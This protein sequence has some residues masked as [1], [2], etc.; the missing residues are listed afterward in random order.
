MTEETAFQIYKDLLR[1]GLSKYTKKAFCVLPE[2]DK[3]RI[4]DIGCGSGVPTMELARLSD[5]QI[6]GLDINQSL[7]DRLAIKVEEAGLTDRVKTLKCSIFDMDFPDESFDI[8]WSE[9]SIA[10][11]GFKKGLEEWRRL[12]KPNGFLAVHDEMGNVTEKLEQVSGCGY[13]LLEYFTLGEDTWW[14]E[15]YAPLEKRINEI[16]TEHATDPEVL[17]ELD[18]DQQEIDMFKKNPGRYT[19]VFFIMRKSDRV[20]KT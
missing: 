4:L 20:Q 9:G 18:N 5:G 10:A 15:Y 14:I 6:T 13:E 1:E 11:I 16:R 2:L 7:L 19:S 8:I 12:L 17:V 3:P